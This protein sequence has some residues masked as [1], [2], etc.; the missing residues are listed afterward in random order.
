MKVALLA[1]SITN[2]KAA[3]LSLILADVGFVLL[4]GRGNLA[5]IAEE[6]RVGRRRESARLISPLDE[7]IFAAGEARLLEFSFAVAFQKS[8]DH[9]GKK[10]QV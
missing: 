4:G 3:A 8:V 9:D 1:G 5:G 6:L 2:D 7:K 10:N